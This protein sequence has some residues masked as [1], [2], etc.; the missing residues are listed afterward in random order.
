MFEELDSHINGQLRI[1]DELG[2]QDHGN[3]IRKRVSEWN[4][5]NRALG[6]T[7]LVLQQD[8]ELIKNIVDK[9][10]HDR[11]D[12]VTMLEIAK[13]FKEGKSDGKQWVSWPGE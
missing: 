6:N 9:V 13:S 12:F 7:L 4:E 5:L 10:E 8:D 11:T 1:K 3:D 2:S